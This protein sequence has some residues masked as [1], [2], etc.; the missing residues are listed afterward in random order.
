MAMAGAL[1]M[2]LSAFAGDLTKSIA[3]SVRSNR[4]MPDMVDDVQLRGHDAW[5]G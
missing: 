5:I 3:K 1:A 2:S 4:R